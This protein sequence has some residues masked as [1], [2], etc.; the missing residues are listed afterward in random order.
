MPYFCSDEKEKKS[1]PKGSN[2]AHE[3]ED[4]VPWEEVF[5]DNSGKFR[6]KSKQGNNYF[7]VFVCAK[8]GDKIAIPQVKRKHFP[9]V[10]FEFTKRIGRHPK[11]LY[12]DLASEITNSSFERYL[13]VKGVNHMNVLRGEHH[14]TGVA[15][16]AIQDLSNMMLN[17][18][19]DSNVPNIYWDFVVEHA[20]LVKS[21]I[22][23]SIAILR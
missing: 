22:T 1:L 6:R 16:K 13:L 11:L 17:M 23:P 3:L 7:T 19:S 18:L 12:S 8:T 2:S 21:M 9:L 10:Y 15:G 20:A 5:T 14:S 4:L